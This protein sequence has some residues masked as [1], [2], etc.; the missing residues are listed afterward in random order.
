MPYLYET[1]LH[2]SPV[3]RCAKASVEE[4]V[5]YYKSLGYAGVFITNHFIS[6][7]D[8]AQVDLDEYRKS[9][10]YYCS[11]YEEGARLGEQMGISVF[12][13]IEM[14]YHTAHFLVYGLDPAWLLSHPEI[15][16]IPMPDKLAFLK[17]AGALVIHAHPYR[18]WGEKSF[19]RLFPHHVHGVEMVNTSQSPFV[20]EMGKI[21]TKG[22]GLLPFAGSDNHAAHRKRVLGGMMSERPIES[23][24]DFVSAV[25]SGEMTPFINNVDENELLPLTL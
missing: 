9:I 18:D 16:T 17:D 20:N 3:S 23:V 4:S 25:K 8:I 6:T 1:H 5:A 11:D 10:E 15:V 7:T 14:S 24:A 19:L 21:Y 2:T 12:F 13:G 22:Y